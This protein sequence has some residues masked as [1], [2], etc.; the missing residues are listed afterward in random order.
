MT[1]LILIASSNAWLI[2]IGIFAL[3]FALNGSFLL[4]ISA[5]LDNVADQLKDNCPKEIEHS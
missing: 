4:S 5:L 2:S 3:I 1:L